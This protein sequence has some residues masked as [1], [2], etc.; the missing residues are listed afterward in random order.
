[1]T[2]AQRK[3]THE[4]I[5]A[6]THEQVAAIVRHTFPRVRGEHIDG[7]AKQLI[8]G[9]HAEVSPRNHKRKR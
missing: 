4:N 3:K 5:N 8:A 2:K 6:L 1:M 7:L 9:A